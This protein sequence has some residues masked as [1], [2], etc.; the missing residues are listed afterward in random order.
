[1][2][3]LTKLIFAVGLATAS[4]GAVFAAETAAPEVS[5][6][7]LRG[8]LHLLQGKGGNVVV[9]VGIDGILMVDGDYSS[10]FEGYKAALETISESNLAPSFLLNTH[11]HEDHTGSNE[12]WALRGSVIFAHDNVRQR[13]STRQ[14]IPALDKVVEPSPR[15]ALPVVTYADSLALHFN[16]DDVEVQHYPAGHTDGDSV[17]FYSR[18]NVVHVGDL[19]FKD[20]FPFVDIASGGSVSGYLANIESVLQRLDDDTL[21]VPGHGAL[22]NKADLERF[23]G[24]ISATSVAVKAA[25]AQGMS[26]DAIVEKGLGEQWATWGEGFIDEAIWIK[27][28]AES[29]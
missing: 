24:M 18:E 1:M 28:L 9:S 14:E 8:P 4:V 11:W 12:Q 23:H 16:G 26:V 19:L 22:A 2:N 7:A 21:V 13:M 3:K 27:T 5:A 10:H 25:L 29:P 15:L 20:R 6:T 17:V